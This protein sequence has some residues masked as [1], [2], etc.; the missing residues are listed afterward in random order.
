MLKIFIFIIVIILSTSK[1][2]TQ[3]ISS[4]GNVDMI[5]SYYNPAFTAFEN[6]LRVTAFYRILNS[7]SPN[8]KN[9][10]RESIVLAE[11]ELNDWNSG[12]GLKLHQDNSYLAR[13]RNAELNYRYS[14]HIAEHSQLSLG[15]SGGYTDYFL[16]TAGLIFSDGG[17]P[18]NLYGGLRS[19]IIFNTGMGY[20][21]N[22]TL[23]LG[24]SVMQIN[25]P[26]VGN[27]KN[28]RHYALHGQ[29]MFSISE[30]FQ[31]QPQFLWLFTKNQNMLRV[32][33]KGYHFERFWWLLS[34]GHNHK[35]MAAAGIQV[36]EHFNIGYGFDLFGFSNDNL[37]GTFHE[38]VL[39][40]KMRK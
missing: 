34:T 6:D 15:L 8:L 26:I 13:K 38:V 25:E 29:Y 14:F 5:D 17:T 33:I 23:Y 24:A 7:S 18:E 30:S 28:S 2:F 35:F 16:D 9:R 32:N 3:Q 11:I 37:I 10:W 20:N 22:N 31:L 4:F 40:Y 12:F 27:Y 19:G 1:A 21:W 36:F 39:S